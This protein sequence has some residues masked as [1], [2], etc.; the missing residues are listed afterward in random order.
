MGKSNDVVVGYKYYMGVHAALCHGPVDNV[1]ELIVGERSA[2]QG[3][4]TT[5]GVINVDNPSLFGGNDRE[6]GVVGQIDVLMGEVYQPVNT[7]LASKI[8]GPVPAYRGILSTVFRTGLSK[9]F[10]WSS[11]NPYFKAPWFRV[12]RILKGWSRGTPWYPAKAAI[13]TLDMNPAHIVYEC[14]TDLNWGM[15]YNPEDLDDVNFSEVADTLHSEGFGLSLLWLEQDSIGNFIDHVLRHV[16]GVR[17][18]DISTGKLQIKLIRNDY[19]PS[20]LPELNTS[21]IVAVESFQRPALGD[22]ISEV[23]VRYT[24]REQNQATVTV[25]NLALI[26][27]QNAVIGVTRDYPGIRDGALAS[28]VAIRDLIT[29]SSPLAKVTL[30]CNRIAWNWLEGDVFRLTWSPLKIT[31]AVYRIL[32][33]DKGTLINGEIAIEAI[34][35]IFQMPTSGYVSAPTSGWI[36]PRSDPSAVTSFKLIE[37]PYWDIVRSTSTSDFD[38]LQPG[39]AFAELLATKPTSDANYFT[40]MHSPNNGTYT[41]VVNPAQFSPSGSIGTAIP[42]GAANVVIVPASLTD[43]E[44][45]EVGDYFYIDNEAFGVVAITSEGVITASRGV[46]DTVPAAHASGAKIYVAPGWHAVDRTERSTGESAYYRALTV[47]GKGT[48][49]LGSAPAMNMTMV[50]RAHAPYPPGNMLVNG[51]V[52]PAQVLTTDGVIVSFSHRDRLQQTVDLVPT[53]T[54]NIGPEAGTTYNMTVRDGTNAVIGTYTG[55][56]SPYTIPAG[57]TNTAKTMKIE[58]V[59]VVGGTLSWQALSHTFNIVAP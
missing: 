34:E 20:A 4:M 33:I 10:L 37:A 52:Y 25:H 7:Y 38:Y 18:Y 26:D 8:V 44:M 1:S 5:T 56:T 6:G 59:S 29:S 19:T 46:L 31:D 16:D 32:K 41:S 12:T 9:G 54:G 58:I 49:A 35:D 21:N 24:D 2:W 17:R 11:M 28:R 15:G 30:R 48:L 47:T 14:Y 39:W 42:I 45:I 27:A 36:D 53:T 43:A 3:S 50:G 13:N 22:L 40:M 51:G 57:I 23:T 55:I